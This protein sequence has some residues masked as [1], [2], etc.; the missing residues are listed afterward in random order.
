MLASLLFI[1]MQ[2]YYARRSIVQSSEWEKAKLTI[3]N[4]ER[5][6]EKMES[7]PLSKDNMFVAGDRLWPDASD[8]AKYHLTDTLRTIYWSL[9]ETEAAPMAELIRLIETMDAFAFPIIMGY[10]SE[11]ISY[12]SAMRQF[13]T[14][15]NF[16]MPQLFKWKMFIGVY[17]KPLYKLWRIRFEI[18]NIDL[19]I[20][21]LE[22]EGDEKILQEDLIERKDYLI[23]YKAPDF[24]LASLKAYRKTLDKKLRE[25]QKEIERIR[26]NSLK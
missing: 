22:E 15:G 3:E 23:C 25:A 24:S 5:F 8:T 4:I 6:K 9:F 2:A 13:Y 19:A 7:S 26:E 10:A 18:M 1:M 11:E 21:L 12:Q 14:Y 20:K 17:A 16:V